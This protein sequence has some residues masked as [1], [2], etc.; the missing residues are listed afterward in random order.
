MEGCM[1]CLHIALRLSSSSSSSSQRKQSGIALSSSINP[2][3]NF[4]SNDN[5]GRLTQMATEIVAS[6]AKHSAAANIDALTRP[7]RPEPGPISLNSRPSEMLG[8]SITNAISPAIT[9]LAEFSENRGLLPSGQQRRSGYHHIGSSSSDTKSLMNIAGAFLGSSRPGKSSSFG[10]KTQTSTSDGD[11]NWLPTIRELAPGANSN[12]GIPKGEGCLPFLSEF[13]RIAYGNCVKVADEKAWD[14]WGNQINNALFG[15]KIDF[16]GATK[17][18]C[19]RGAERQH[20]GQ[21]RKVI[22]E[23]DILGSLQVGMEM[24]RAIQ[25]CEEFSGVIDQNPIQVLNQVNSIIGGEFAQGFL[26]K[27]LG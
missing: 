22:S 24:Q 23:C 17:E 21:L 27:F 16:I 2:L 10:T 14:L 13:M 6:A 11:I 20:C 1:K 3:L 5:I 15:G 8:Q 25:R 7:G 9:K 18:T 19:K 4:L 12:F 26:H